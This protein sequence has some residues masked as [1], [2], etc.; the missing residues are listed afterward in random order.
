MD[1]LTLIFSWLSAMLY[2]NPLIV[3]FAAFIWGILSVVLSPC[4]LSSIPLAI[5]YINGK[6]KVSNY[7]V[8]ALSA[9][10]S[11]GILISLISL[12]VLTSLLG[13][14]MGDTGR[15]T[16]IIVGIVFVIVGLS[17]L[18]FI[19]I[20][21]VPIYKAKVKSQSLLG[22]FILG[23]LFGVALGPCTFG[24]MM[25]VLA[26]AFQTATKNLIFAVAMMVAFSF[27][28]TLVIIFAGTFINFVQ[29]ILNWEEKSK[30]IVY[31]RRFCGILI[32]VSGVVI[33]I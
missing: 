19:R 2:R 13:R 12:G 4:H 11:V 18:D 26:L 27:G 8:V 22:A 7:R 17:F 20:P 1:L 25:P 6:G 24:F 29:T 14:M 32:I 21:K 30:A 5:G 16:L 23:L 15:L 33:I 3:F 9:L 28:H 10:F 31:F